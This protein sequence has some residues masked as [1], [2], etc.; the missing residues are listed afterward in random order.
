VAKA[1]RL[2]AEERR[3]SILA[4]AWE[5]LAAAPL[6]AVT[7][8]QIVTRVG[9]TRPIFY[10][11][12]D[13]RNDLLASLYREWAED[14]GDRTQAAIDDATT[15]D[16]VMVN[17][18]RVYLDSFTTR[19][20]TIRE[21][22]NHV[23]VVA[24]FSEERLKM[25]TRQTELL[26]GAVFKY[27]NELDLSDREVTAEIRLFLAILVE[28]GIMVAMGDA[29]RDIVEGAILRVVRAAVGGDAT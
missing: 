8:D 6:E 12:F 13:D 9:V 11:H 14:L 2:S 7:I 10:R 21:L 26:V 5:L 25:R 29:T 22:V 27:G 18:T 3:E 1:D 17:A 23:G 28:G 4:A 19:G 15:I 20:T 24:S 16:Q